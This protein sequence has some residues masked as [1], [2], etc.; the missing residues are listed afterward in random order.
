MVIINYESQVYVPTFY[1]SMSMTFLNIH[2]DIAYDKL[3][4]F[5]RENI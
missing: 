3:Y 1:I 5:A 4:Q 2:I